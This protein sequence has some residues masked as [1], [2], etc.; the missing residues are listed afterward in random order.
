MKFVHALL[1]AASAAAAQAQPTALQMPRG[2]GS[3]IRYYLEPR[4]PGQTSTQLLLV[5]QGSDCNSVTQVSAIRRDIARAWPQ[6]DLLTVEKYGIDDS[7][8]YDSDPERSD[9]PVP[10][11]EHDS[12]Q[13]R[14]GDLDMV[15]AALRSAHGYRQVVAIGGSEGAAVA[16][17]LAAHS[18]HVDA[19]IAF[20][21]GGQWF[22]NDIVHSLSS[23]PMPASERRKAEQ[24]LRAF[25]RH[26]L[27]SPPQPMAMSGHGYRWWRDTL[28]LDQLALLRQSTRPVLIMQAG[29]DS[30]VSPQ[31]TLSMIA[32]LHQAGKRN[33][34]YRTYPGLNH[35]MAEPGGASHLSRVADDMAMWLRQVMPYSD[36]A[37]AA[38]STA[39][40]ASL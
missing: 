4:V 12:P 25:A 14:A 30:S 26:V 6:A 24:G 5:L 15:L 29:A 2:D 27:Q 35:A 28:E 21:G 37:R 18:P 3:S 31:S 1:L 11:L 16:N 32:R 17:L 10:Y 9:C 40:K 8:P 34:S 22:L 20:N 33:I 36:G 38:D 19:T 7:L 23:E 39:R 13:Q